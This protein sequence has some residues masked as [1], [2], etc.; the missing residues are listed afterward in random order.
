MIEFSSNV[1]ALLSKPIVESFNMVRI[2][3]YLTTDLYIDA[4]LSDG[5][6]Y[7]SDGKLVRVE[8]PRLVSIVDSAEYAVTFAD[9]TLSFG[10]TAANLIGKRF[11]VRLGFIDPDTDA[12]LFG[13][14]D[15]VLAYAGKVGASTYLKN[16][17]PLGDV[18]FEVRG[19]SPMANFDMVRTFH[20]TR[21]FLSKLSPDDTAFDQVYDGAG[22][23]KVRWGKK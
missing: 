12:P 20:T 3:D 23:V 7:Q 22:S 17:S 11:E 18:L 13:I 5:S 4:A 9:P 19:S 1:L 15:T 6:T 16:T 14:A 2:G 21:D 10:E 8:S